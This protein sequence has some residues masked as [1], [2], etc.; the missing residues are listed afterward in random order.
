MTAARALAGALAL[1]SALAGAARAQVPSGRPQSPPSRPQPPAPAP[2]AP[3]PAAPAP[4][5]SQGVV[6]AAQVARGVQAYQNLD[7][8]SAAVL[9]RGALASPGAAT[10]SDSVRVRA[11]VFLG[12]TELYRDRRDTAAALFG[13]ALRI[14]PRYHIDQLVFPPEVTGLFQQVRAITR[15]VTVVVPADT[16]MGAPRDLLP[17]RLYAAS[18]HPVDVAMMRL[19]G[20]RLR[21]VYQGNVGDS[22]L[23]TWDGRAQD[24]NPPDSGRYTLQVDSR[25]AE[26]RIVRTVQIPLD[27]SRVKRDTLPLPPPPPASRFR[28][29]HRPGTNG[30]RGAVAG[31]V[32]VLAVVAL[33][34]LVAGKFEASGDRLL[35]AAGFGAAGF[36]GFR[37]QRGPQPI[38]ENIAANRT[39]RVAWQHQV[40]SVHTQNVSRRQE[41]RLR[42]RSGTAQIIGLQ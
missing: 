5:P 37:A 21:T 33:P 28:P 27:I 20:T 35:V 6:L 12:A 3:A 14:D 38:P 9:L 22:L 36:L 24:G 26:G 4:A 13:R 2:Q 10:L 41:I 7:Y 8:D 29:E 42:V 15:A 19:D 16:E 25:S 18:F 40:D 31:A 34:S 17:I 32:G 11:L 1:A 39:I 23:V 30:V